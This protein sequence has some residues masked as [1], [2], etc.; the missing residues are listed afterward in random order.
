MQTTKRFVVVG[1]LLVVGLPTAFAQLEVSGDAV[2]NC[3]QIDALRNAGNLSEARNKAQLCLE[4]LEQELAGA[5]GRY[6]LPEIAGWNRTSLEQ[7]QALGFT[8]IS[9]GYQKGETRAT[10]SLT[11]GTSGAGLGGLLGGFARMGLASSGKQVRVAG[12]PASVQADGSITVTLDDGS[13]LSFDSP[14][15]GDPDA[16][17]A[18]IG[19]LVNGFPVADINEALK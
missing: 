1:V 14:E 11:G 6:F 2:D 7:N 10:V 19:D 8:N 12:L 18:G 13:L 15:F 3:S 5:V 4:A 16:A 17:L 9:A